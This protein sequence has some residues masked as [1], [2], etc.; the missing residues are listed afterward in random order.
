MTYT[1]NFV[2]NQLGKQRN[3]YN[4][5]HRD[6]EEQQGTGFGKVGKIRPVLFPG[7]RT[8]VLPP[9]EINSSIVH[10]QSTEFEREKENIH[11]AL[12]RKAHRNRPRSS[13]W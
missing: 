11:Y 10:P 12:A 1:L 7:G 8:V 4:S 3:G 6:P 13:G 5:S 2:M 9:C